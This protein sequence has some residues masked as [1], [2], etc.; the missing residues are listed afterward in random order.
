MTTCSHRVEKGEW[1]PIHKVAPRHGLKTR[2]PTD[3]SSEEIENN[4]VVDPNI[5]VPS[6]RNKEPLN[7]RSASMIKDEGS[8][9][10]RMPQG[11]HSHQG[12]SDDLHNHLRRTT[13]DNPTV[14][15]QIQAQANQTVR[16]IAHANSAN[17]S[18][19][20]KL[21]RAKK[22]LSEIITLL[23]DTQEHSIH[24]EGM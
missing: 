3:S 8:R 10:S 17:E 24:P 16:H 11:Q 13:I 14:V 2:R 4:E 20:H 1:S 6:T 9:L 22:A 23:D 7:C 5:L 12:A 21:D 15:A 19:G 18:T